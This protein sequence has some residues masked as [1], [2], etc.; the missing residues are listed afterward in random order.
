MKKIYIILICNF[1]FIVNS[2]SDDWYI[3]HDDDYNNYYELRSYDSLHYVI[4]GVFNKLVDN[5]I[6]W[7][8][9]IK[10]T[11]DAGLSWKIIWKDEMKIPEY[12]TPRKI[13]DLAILSNKIIVAGI[14]GGMIIHTTNQG[15]TWDTTNF[16]INEECTALS[17]FDNQHGAAHFLKADFIA[18]SDDY[19]NTWKKISKPQ[20]EDFDIK[21]NIDCIERIN[22][23]LFKMSY[24]RF[25]DNTYWIITSSDKGKNWSYFNESSNYIRRIH[26]LN[27]KIGWMGGNVIMNGDTSI[28][29]KTTDGGITWELKYQIPSQANF[30]FIEVVDKDTVYATN[31]HDLVKTSDGGDTWTVQTHEIGEIPCKI[32]GIE[33]GSKTSGLTISRLNYIH[34]NSITSDVH[35]NKNEVNEIFISPNPV[36][37]SNL[38]NISF[39]TQKNVT[40]KIE[41]INLIGINIADIYSGFKEA[42]EHI[43]YFK[44]DNSMSAGTYWIRMVINGKKQIIKPLLIIN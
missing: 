14:E 26:F 6:T 1:L 24:Y 13:T 43:I 9:F 34:S 35:S 20:I 29:K 30:N 21:Y 42:G 8:S 37:Y 16:E 33:F 27:E 40:I 39:T 15:E 19:G 28:I 4:S 32:I 17:F 22:D 23:S 5:E 44:P 31:G 12:N 18:I 41:L 2:N 11:T 38:I 7:Y 10:I 3:I 36:N 25:E